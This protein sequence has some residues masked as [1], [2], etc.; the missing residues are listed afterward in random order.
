MIVCF[1]DSRSRAQKH[2]QA[3][4]GEDV[5]SNLTHSVPSYVFQM[6]IASVTLY[7]T[8]GLLIVVQNLV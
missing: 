8:F 3:Q 7:C 1:K 5:S 6:R 2:I 4:E